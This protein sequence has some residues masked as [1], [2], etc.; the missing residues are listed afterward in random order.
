[1]RATEPPATQIIPTD[2]PPLPT[3]RPD[4][5][6]LLGAIR[7]DGWYGGSPYVKNLFPEEWRYRLPF[8]AAVSADGQVQMAS[9]SQEVMDQEILYASASGKRS[10]M[11]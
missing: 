7:W 10:S 8:Y 5:G 9:D 4:D 11:R 6:I 2:L 1:M 3:P